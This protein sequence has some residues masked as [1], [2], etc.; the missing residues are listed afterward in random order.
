MLVKAPG[1]ELAEG[2]FREILMLQNK[3]L[4]E[5]KQQHNKAK[6]GSFGSSS[7][8]VETERSRSDDDEFI[9]NVRSK[10][11]ECNHEENLIRFD[12]TRFI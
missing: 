11:I 1:K 5:L 2:K 9:K 6:T 10:N 4:A 3:T 12:A 7:V 8:D